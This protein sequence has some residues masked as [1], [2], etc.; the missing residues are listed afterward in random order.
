MRL[1]AVAFGAVCFALF[2]LPAGA[3]NWPNFRGPQSSG[4]SDEKDLPAKWS[5]SENL[6][7]KIDLPGPGASSPVVWGD[8]VFVTC[9][10]GYGVKSRDPGNQEDLRR[11][12]I[13]VD[14]KEGKILWDK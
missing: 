13:C 7:W 10:S 1:N 9:Y 4:I 6:V 5:D 2:T 3:A 8:K 11:H 12:L 14:R